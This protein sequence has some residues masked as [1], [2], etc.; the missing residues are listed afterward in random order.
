MKST[1]ASV[2]CVFLACLAAAAAAELA[3]TD[4]ETAPEAGY[5]ETV[6]PNGMRVALAERREVPMVSATAIIGAGS[7]LESED[8]SG[9]S[10]LLEHLLFNGTT[11]MNQEEL[12]AAVDRIGGYSNAHTDE[13]HT[14]FTMLVPTAHA[15]Q[16]LEIQ[17]AMLFDSTIPQD[18]YGK[19][20]KIVLEEIAKDRSRPDHEVDLTIRERTSPKTAYARPVIGTYDSLAGIERDR[21]WEYYERRYVPE[22]T[23]LFVAGDFAAGEML[24]LVERIYDPAAAGAPRPPLPPIPD[25][26]AGPGDGTVTR[27]GKEAASAVI[28]VTLPA[29]GPC[30]AGGLDASIMASILSSE[31]G[32][33]RRAVPGDEATRISATYVPRPV[34]SALSIRADLLPGT[35]SGAVARKLL[36]ALDATGRR[37]LNQPGFGPVEVMRASAAARSGELLMGQRLHYLG[38]M[39]ADTLGACTGSLAP[40]LR[41]DQRPEPPPEEVAATAA[42]LFDDLARRARVVVVDPGARETTIEPIGEIVAAARAE[43]PPPAG[44]TAA[45]LDRTLDNG[46]R[47][48]ASREAGT[49]VTGFHLLVRDR[50]AREP[51]GQDGIADLLHRLLPR[52]TRLSDR[53]QLEARL[54]RLGAELKTAD[55]DFIPYDDY[56]TSPSHSFVRLEVQSGNWLPALDL[57]AELVRLPALGQGEFET[58]H[59]ARLVRAEKQASSPT[60]VG[61]TA[62]RAALLGADHPLARPLVGSPASLGRLTHEDLV[63]FADAY[64]GARALVLSVVG[65][66]EPED[67][68]GAVAERFASAAPGPESPTVTSWPLTGTPGP[69]VEVALGADQAKIYLGFIDE[70]AAADRPGLTLLAAIASDR[71]AMTLR[72]EL[73]LA[74][75]L[76]ASVAFSAEPALAWLTLEMGTRP[77]NRDQALAGLRSQMDGLRTR[78]VDDEDIERIRA[79]LRSRALMR[80]MTAVNRARYLGLRA[81]TGVEA[82]EDLDA[83]EAL[84]QVSRDQLERLAREWLDPARHRAVIVH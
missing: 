10:H 69:A 68:F 34:G 27:V 5:L 8:F 20:R 75:R 36:E 79:V 82:R 66:H 42:L 11:T 47:V 3:P 37:G 2:F 1:T 25:P 35:D 7:A 15:A 22:N 41:P 84:D 78:M 74:Y 44:L 73:G 33:L 9:A 40:L 67:V 13:D 51:E 46:M 48:L 63:E 49:Q 71:L 60:E 29:P 31:A 21:V 12:Y 19:E 58:L 59:A 38:M 53:A 80:R 72:E 50:S 16:G 76:G 83:L 26:F 62:Y 56:Y 14:Y 61:R 77:E 64:L 70:V 24:K 52:G 43:S 45:D 65:P 57:L 32:P 30:E 18:K 39:V 17:A 55:S 6:L 54:E 28:S 81:F 4:P 23:L